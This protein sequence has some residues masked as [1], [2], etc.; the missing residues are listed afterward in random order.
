MA[1][2]DS[3]H[4][5][6]PSNM[7]PPYKCAVCEATITHSEYGPWMAVPVVED[8]HPTPVDAVVEGMESMVK[9]LEDPDRFM[10][11]QMI[12]HQAVGQLVIRLGVPNPGRI[13]ALVRILG[14]DVEVTPRCDFCD[15][16]FEDGGEGEDW[17]GDTG[18]HLSCERD[19]Q[20][21]LGG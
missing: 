21:E 16:P 6:Y 12:F 9:H 13:E 2:V 11:D 14:P 1:K 17:N 20:L 10:E 7:K 15:E 18:N 19:Y 4:S 5:H 8:S 3:G